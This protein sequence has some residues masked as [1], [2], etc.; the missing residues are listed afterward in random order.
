M[1]M[2]GTPKNM[3]K[4][5]TYKNVVEEI[6]NYFQK[7]I[8]ALNNL[9]IN[10]LIIDPGFGFGKTLDHNYE[11]LNNLEK[12]KCLKYPILA[13]LSRKSMICKI[14]DIEANH[15]L[16][17]TSVVN[18]MALNKGANILRVHDVKE[19]IECIKITNFAKNKL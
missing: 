6:I 5:P 14:L 15:A 10:K 3:Q 12:F 11:I 18:T 4:N 16:N 2:K 13:G 7:K 8:R 1:H 17:G 19:A 9:N